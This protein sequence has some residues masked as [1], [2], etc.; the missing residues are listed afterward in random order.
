MLEE[1]IVRSGAHCS[2]SEG[3]EKKKQPVTKADFFEYGLSGGENSV[4]KREKLKKYLGLPERMTANLMLET[5][6]CLMTR[7]EFIALYSNFE[8][9]D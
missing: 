1:A 8:N 9:G 7:D 4:Q 2:I 6:N 5:I 3:H